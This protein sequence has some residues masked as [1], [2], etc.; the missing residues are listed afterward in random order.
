MPQVGS[1]TEVCTG[2]ARL[3][4]QGAQSTAK[5]SAALHTPPAIATRTICR[6]RGHDNSAALAGDR[7][8]ACRTSFSEPRAQYS[9]TIVG[10]TC[11]ACG[12]S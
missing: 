1:Y 3:S 7:R 4:E 2:H 5:C 10:G 8:A 12:S 6:R 9:V 11:D